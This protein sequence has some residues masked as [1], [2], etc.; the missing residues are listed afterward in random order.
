MVKLSISIIG[1]KIKPLRKNDA[2][3]V[4]RYAMEEINRDG[5]VDIRD[6]V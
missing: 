4:N 5:E 1:Y 6:D 2:H 3:M